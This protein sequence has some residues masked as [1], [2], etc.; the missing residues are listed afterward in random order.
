MIPY[1]IRNLFDK[2]TYAEYYFYNDIHWKEKC[3]LNYDKYDRIHILKVSKKKKVKKTLKRNIL[4][5]III[6]L[7]INYYF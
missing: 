5:I 6:I 1:Y 3:Y 7:W 2:D 4:K